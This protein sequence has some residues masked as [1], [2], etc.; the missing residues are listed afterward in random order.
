MDKHSA[1]Q[2]FARFGLAAKGVVYMLIAGLALGAALGSGRAGDSQEA[3]STLRNVQLGG[4][5]LGIIG[6]GLLAYALWRLY[7]G[8]A[9]PEG[10]KAGKR[11]MYVGTGLINAGLGLEAVRLGFLSG[12][13]NTG[14]KAPHWTAEL[15]SK[16]FG[17][18]LVAGAGA[19]IAGYGVAQVLRAAQSRL[20]KY[21][22]LGEL[23]GTTRLWVRRLARVGIAARG[24][25]F[26]VAGGFLIKA[27]L[28]HDPSEA[29][30]LGASL[31]MVE[32]QPFGK[33]LL[34][35]IALGLF[36]YGFYNLVR[37][38]YRVIQT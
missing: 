15:M 6:I 17:V 35:G 8:I 9:N 19:I 18:W 11:F 20:D 23:E 3:M 26:L 12:S 38:R 31:Q 7:S 21:L 37:A 28:E 34:T 24:L 25:V 4:L 32:Q 5:M 33:W 1:L 30:D 10:E 29:R 27:S 14:N 16:P 22:R 2:A 13:A 36:L